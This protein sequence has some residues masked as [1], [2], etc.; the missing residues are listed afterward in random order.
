MANALLV[1]D[2]QQYFL[3]SAPSDL[4]QRIV[5][6]HQALG[7]DDVIFTIFKN[8]PRSNFVS[9]LQWDKCNTDDDAQLPQEFNSL[10]TPDNVFT[11]AAYSAFKTTGLDSYLRQKGIDR[12]VLCGIDS[13]ACV[14]ATGFE[15]F[16][17]GYHINVDFSLTYSSNDLDKAAQLIATRNII[18][19][20]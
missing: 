8:E 2:V 7:Y 10:I 14:L 1:V 16:D 18:S 12:L 5:N 11:R 13:D 6:H 19:R 9:S 15:A 4:P 20:D 17:L 3:K